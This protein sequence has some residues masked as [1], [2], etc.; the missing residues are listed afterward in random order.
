MQQRFAQVLREKLDDENFD[1][2]MQLENP[3][4]HQF[5]AESIR[6]CRP[7]SVF[8]CTDS[9]DDINYIRR[10]AVATGEEKPLAIKG[11]TV[12]FDG[13][14]DQARDKKTTRY[15]VPEGVDLGENVNTVPR[16]LSGADPFGVLNRRGSIDRLFLCGSQ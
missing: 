12:H 9:A 4:L 2:L 16:H 14:A 3:K 15:L 10:Q 7:A 13:F 1:K 11:H 5:V 8:V 6:L